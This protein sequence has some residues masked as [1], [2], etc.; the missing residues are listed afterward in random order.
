MNLRSTLTEKERLIVKQLCSDK[1]QKEIAYEFGISE[2]TIA[3]HVMH[4]YKKYNVK[5]RVGLLLR[6]LSENSEQ[7]TELIQKALEI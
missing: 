4:I 5:T 1:S 3:T 2:K 7:L 6:V